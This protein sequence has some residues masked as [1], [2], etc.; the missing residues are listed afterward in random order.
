MCAHQY[1]LMRTT[2]ELSDNLLKRAKLAALQNNTTLKA[3]VT[4]AL[5]LYL[6]GQ[7]RKSES[8]QSGN[9]ETG[10][11]GQSSVK[12]TRPVVE[13]GPDSPISNLDSNALVTKEGKIWKQD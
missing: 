2:I 7:L 3:M 8:A 6:D 4:E 9:D 1:S 10:A 11:Q 12:F 13:T 5:E